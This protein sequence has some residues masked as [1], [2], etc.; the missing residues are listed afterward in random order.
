MLYSILFSQLQNCID[1]QLQIPGIDA[2]ALGPPQAAQIEIVQ[3]FQLFP[4]G[5][6]IHAD[7]EVVCH[8]SQAL[9]SGGGGAPST[10]GA[11]AEVKLP[12]QGSDADVIP[13]AKLA[14]AFYN[15]HSIILLLWLASL[16]TFILQ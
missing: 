8:L 4:S 16:H 1:S 6:V 10:D 14:D 3:S 12:F 15:I 7:P 13:G 2:L 5:E 9:H 11:I